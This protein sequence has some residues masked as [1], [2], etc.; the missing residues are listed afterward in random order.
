MSFRRSK[1]WLMASLL[2]RAMATNMNATI[3]A[4]E[5]EGRAA[6]TSPLLTASVSAAEMTPM[7]MAAPIARI[8]GIE[9]STCG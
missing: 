2:T 8:N 5:A 6:R 3:T 7:A 9:K 1:L 4:Y